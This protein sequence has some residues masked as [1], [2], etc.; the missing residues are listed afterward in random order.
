MEEVSAEGLLNQEFLGGLKRWLMVAPMSILGSVAIFA[1]LGELTTGV[2]M[3]A[4][5]LVGAV[6]HGWTLYKPV[7]VRSNWFLLGC[8]VLAVTAVR[9]NQRSGT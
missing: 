2:V 5:V 3:S 6:L 4:T 8:L 1:F 7:F 9:L